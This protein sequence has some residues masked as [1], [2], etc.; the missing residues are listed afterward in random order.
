MRLKVFADAGLMKGVPPVEGFTQSDLGTPDWEKN[1]LDGDNDLQVRFP[2]KAGTRVIAFAIPARRWNPDESFVLPPRAGREEER[3]GNIAI[4]QVE[5]A[6]PFNAK[7]PVDSASRQKI[8]TCQ[9]AGQADQEACATTIL[10]TIARKA[11]RRPLVK[12]DVQALQ[13]FCRAGMERG[14]D[15]CIQSGLERILASPYFLFRVEGDA[16]A[17][18]Q[19]APTHKQ[20]GQLGGGFV[21]RNAAFGLTGKPAASAGTAPVGPTRLNDLDLASRLSFFLWSSIPD[22]QLLDLATQSKLHESGVL[23]QQV[24]RMLADPRS[25]ALVDNFADQWLELRRLDGATPVEAVFPDFDGELRMAM[26][27]ETERFIDSMLRDDR[28]VPER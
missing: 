28:P 26:R 17:S 4:K 11:Y 14:F 1:S 24:K 3:D 2:A 20:V 10:T 13:Q 27:E 9:P 8:F 23:N 12:G 7:P 21:I 25:R 19:P 16:S 6:G 18:D 5:I 22:D 15:G